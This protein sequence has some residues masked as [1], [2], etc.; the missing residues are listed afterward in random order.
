M[1]AG[2]RRR[3]D[4]DRIQAERPLRGGE[5]ARRHLRPGGLPRLR[6]GRARVRLERALGRATCRTRGRDRVRPARARRARARR[7]AASGASASPR[8]SRSAG[9][10]TRSR[11]TRCSS[12]TNERSCRPSSS[13][14]SGSRRRRAR[15]ASVGARV[16]DEVRRA[17]RRAALAHVPSSP[18]PRRLARFAA[19]FGVATLSRSRSCCSSRRSRRVPH[20]L[21]PDVRV[22]ARPRLPFSIWD[23]GQYHALGIPDLA[24]LQTVVQV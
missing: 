12:N 21:G 17:R 4:P 11:P 20:V 16:V 22:P 7:A 13:G 24:S 6:A 14:A 9:R 1:R 23:W 10:R 2:Q 15:G 3:R 18:R 19:G 5:P 8:C